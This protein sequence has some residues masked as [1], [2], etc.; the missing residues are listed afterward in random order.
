MA[1]CAAPAQDDR[2]VV[3]IAEAAKPSIAQ[4]LDK[5]MPTVEELSKTLDV[6]GLMG[7][8]VRGDADVLLAGVGESDASPAECVGAAY[9]LQRVRY[10]SGPVRDV[11][12]QSWAGGP[13]DGPPV[14]GFFGAVRFATPDAAQAFFAS[15][16][17]HWH[18]CNGQTMVLHQPNGAAPT[19]SRIADVTVGD[20]V[21]SA[22]VM[23]DAGA[24]LQRALAVAGDCVVDVEITNADPMA[25]AGQ[26]VSVADL[27][28]HKIAHP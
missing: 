18:T 10:Q 7:Q 1:A 28:V 19:A 23:R 6:S 22:V 9:S 8:L 16:A 27:M 11:A 5:V 2:P 25:D 17:E 3:H 21:I 24:T 20:N 15:S 26:A 14:T 12:S 13:F 4:P